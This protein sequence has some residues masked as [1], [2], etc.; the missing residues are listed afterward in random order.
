MTVV[1]REPDA[2]MDAFTKL[3]DDLQMFLVEK[4]LVAVTK[5]ARG[6]V[7]PLRPAFLARRFDRKPGRPQHEGEHHRKT[8]DN[9]S[10]HWPLSEGRVAQ[11]RITVKTPVPN[12]TQIGAQEL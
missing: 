9:S 4:I 2:C 5:D 8:P 3:L 10:V 6:F 11:A 1:T 12:A 7:P